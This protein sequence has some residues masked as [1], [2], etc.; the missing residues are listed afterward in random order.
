MTNNQSAAA[1][2]FEEVTIGKSNEKVATVTLKDGQA[3]CIVVSEFGVE[4]PM[5]RDGSL[6]TKEQF[7]AQEDADS[8][9]LICQDTHSEDYVITT[10][11]YEALEEDV[12][13]EL[14]EKFF[15]AKQE[16][17]VNVT[18]PLISKE[19]IIEELTEHRNPKLSHEEAEQ[20]AEKV[21]EDA[22]FWM[23]V[24]ALFHGRMDRLRTEQV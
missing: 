19:R 12:L 13:L 2:E 24:E 8:I 4:I 20:L 9:E 6:A 10:E 14:I 18:N 17:A 7:L 11:G 1:F 5:L 23:D 15:P 3:T 16:E 22:S 21:L